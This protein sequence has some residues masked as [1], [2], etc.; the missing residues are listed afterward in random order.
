MAIGAQT[1]LTFCLLYFNVLGERQSSDMMLDW[2]WEQPIRKAGARR[3]FITP[4][5]RQN[6]SDFIT[7]LLLFKISTSL[8]LLHPHHQITHRTTVT[9]SKWWPHIYLSTYMRIHTILTHPQLHTSTHKY[10]FDV[11][12][13]YK[14]D[15]DMSGW[16]VNI[17]RC[18]SVALLL[19]HLNSIVLCRIWVYSV[20]VYEYVSLRIPSLATTLELAAYH[21]RWR[22]KNIV[23]GF[24]ISNIAPTL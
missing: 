15:D 7:T 12:L 10:T 2:E 16:T 3:H 22:L 23:Y 11:F 1:V 17:F 19:Y 9:M 21:Y 18:L 20:C 4:Y 8:A 24:L 14:F 6:S 13:I 5:S